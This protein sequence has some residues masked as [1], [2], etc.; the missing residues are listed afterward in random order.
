MPFGG[1]AAGQ[2]WV[3]DSLARPALSPGLLALALGLSA[4][5][6]G[7]HALTPG[8][9]KS[10][11]GAYLVG[12]RGT[13]AHA[14]FLGGAV[15]LTHTASVLAVGL[16]ALVAG[17]YLVPALFV[18]ALQVGSGVLVVLLGLRLVRTRW[19]SLRH[20]DAHG[21]AHGH[22]HGHDHPDHAH[23]HAD[24]DHAHGHTHAAPA[25]VTWRDLTAMGVSGGLTPCPEAI[26]ILLVAIGLNRIGVGLGLLVA[27]S[28]GLAAVL[29]LIGLLLVRARGLGDRL[30]ARGR[31]ALQLLPLGSAVAVTVL[32]AGICLQ[33][34]ISAGLLPPLDLPRAAASAAAVLP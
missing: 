30:G 7:L 13:A 17:R 10:I 8:H 29:S 28:L 24:Q 11:V 1:A 27:F 3:L 2:R 23:D 5:L 22:A 21:D 20:G 33:G 16:L 19:A 6:G 14:V 18:P 12:S 34:A 15:T 25:A 31:P 32:G 4:L 26:G 9:G